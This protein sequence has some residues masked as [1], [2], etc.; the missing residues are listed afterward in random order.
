[1]QTHLD[2]LRLHLSHEYGRLSQ[3]RTD[4]ERN[5]RRVGIGQLKREIASELAFLGQIEE[6]GTDM[7]D[8][9]LLA[10]LGA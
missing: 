1:M 7:D 6:D 4:K 9:A 2:A 10:E 8:E 3:A 5:W